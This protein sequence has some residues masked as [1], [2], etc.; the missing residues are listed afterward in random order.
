MRRTDGTWYGHQLADWVSP[1]GGS[2]PMIASEASSSE[3]S[4]ICATGFVVRSLEAMLRFAKARGDDAAASLYAGSLDQIRAAFQQ[5][6]YDPE[7][8]CYRTGFWQPL[9]QRTP[10]RLRP[11]S[12]SHWLSAS[13]RLSWPGRLPPG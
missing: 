12:S 2:D 1:A 8:G 3:G 13:R 6:Y 5:K 4:G 10:F 9:G 7:A 11:P